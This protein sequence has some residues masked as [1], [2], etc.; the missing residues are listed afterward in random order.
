MHT[1]T[2]PSL[3]DRLVE[4]VQWFTKPIDE[5]LDPRANFPEEVRR[6]FYVITNMPTTKDTVWARLINRLSEP[7]TQ[8][9]AGEGAVLRLRGAMASKDIRAIREGLLSLKR[10]GHA[11]TAI[12]NCCW[13]FSKLH[14]VQALS[15]S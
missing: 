15:Y 12:L 1:C 8:H 2:S 7:V 14:E 9:V 3:D 10:K 5:K 4:A 6:W 13:N 11:S